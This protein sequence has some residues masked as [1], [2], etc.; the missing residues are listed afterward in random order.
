LI[1]ETAMSDVHPAKKS[2]MI[3]QRQ[4]AISSIDEVEQSAT[5]PSSTL[6]AA[7]RRTML[8][9]TTLESGEPVWLKRSNSS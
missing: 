5:S 3:I 9:E 8:K 1:E 4:H 7:T 6:S 2:V